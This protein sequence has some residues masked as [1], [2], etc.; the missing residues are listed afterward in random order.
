MVKIC[1]VLTFLFC[2]TLFTRPYSWQCI[3]E[4]NIWMLEKVEGFE[5]ATWVFNAFEEEMF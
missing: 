2:K 1:C 3:W 4:V 5:I